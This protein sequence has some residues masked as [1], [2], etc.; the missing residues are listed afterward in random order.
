MHT[1]DL[2]NTH[3]GCDQLGIPH[4]TAK[5][6]LLRSS[7]ARNHA[8][9]SMM[10]IRHPLSEQPVAPAALQCALFAPHTLHPVERKTLLQLPACGLLL[11]SVYKCVI[12]TD[13]M[14]FLEPLCSCCFHLSICSLG[15]RALYGG[16][17]RCWEARLY[18]AQPSTSSSWYKKAGLIV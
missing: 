18:T 17:V 8:K 10:A 15:Q 12:L 4:P 9:W 1:D 2:A 7:K 16:V 13:C 6:S 5:L 14:H 3:A 11:W